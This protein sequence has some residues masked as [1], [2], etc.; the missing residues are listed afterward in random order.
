MS[1][2]LLLFMCYKFTS[3]FTYHRVIIIVISWSMVNYNKGWSINNN[4]IKNNPFYH[5][6][7][8]SLQLQPNIVLQFI[9]PI[10]VCSFFNRFH[11]LTTPFVLRLII[12]V[13][14]NYYY[15]ILNRLIPISS[16]YYWIIL[17]FYFSYFLLIGN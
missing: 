13:A 1:S 9:T 15:I 12:T 2:L 10:F 5:L 11:T 17:Y 14:A 8:I 6:S 16:T 7:I 3:H 4:A